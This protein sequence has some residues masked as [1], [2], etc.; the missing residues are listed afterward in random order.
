MDFDYA[1]ALVIAQGIVCFGSTSDDTVRALDAETGEERW[2]F[3]AGGPVRF[4]PQI[5]NGKVFFASDDG[6]VYCLDAAS[7]NLFWKFRTAPN[8]EMLV[9]NHRMISRWPVRTGVLAA[10]GVVYGVAGVWPAEGIFVYALHADT[11]EI[12]WCNDTTGGTPQGALLA[13]GEVLLVPQGNGRPMAFDRRTGE[14]LEWRSPNAWTGTGGSWLTIADEKLFSFGIHRAGT[15]FIRSY[16]LT[17]REVV[18]RGWGSGVVPQPTIEPQ[19][20]PFQSHE[21]GKVSAIVNGGK[22]QARIAYGMALAGET[23]L[24]GHD[25]QV[26]AERTESLNSEFRFGLAGDDLVVFTAVPD[27]KVA[28]APQPW[29]GS[30][31]EVFASV[32][33][34][35]EIGQI[36]LIPATGT[37][38]AHAYRAHDGKFDPAP[39]IRLHGTATD[40]GYE[41]SALVPLKMLLLDKSG[42]YRLEVQVTIPGPDG[43]VARSTLFGSPRAYQ[44]NEKFGQFSLKPQDSSASPAEVKANL[45]DIKPNIIKMAGTGELWN[46]Q[47]QG[48]ARELAVAGG[49]L[50]VSTSDGVIYCFAPADGS[51]GSPKIHDTAAA[52]R[53]ATPPV[54]T[55]QEDVVLR[56]L[57]EA[58]AER[59]Y[60]LVVGDSDGRLSEILATHTELA[61]VH[62]EA[63]A[64]KA[65][66]LRDRLLSRTPL[67]GSKLHLPPVERLDPLPFPQYFANTV[68][69]AG[70]CPGLSGSELYRLLHPNGGILLFPGLKPAQAESLVQQTGAPEPEIRRLADDWVVVRGKLPGALDWDSEVRTDHRVKW[71]L[72]PLWFG[73]PSTRQVQNYR[74]G[75]PGPV[76]ANG[77]YFMQSERALTAVDAFNGAV[78]WSRPIPRPWPGGLCEVDGV[79]YNVSERSEHEK[80]DFARNLRVNDESVFLTLGKAYFRGYG[81]GMMQLEAHT[82]EQVKVFG[83][84]N[85]PT[86]FSLKTPLTW[87]VKNPPESSGKPPAQPAVKIDLQDEGDSLESEAQDEVNSLIKDVIHQSR[88]VP[89]SEEKA[90]ANLKDQDACLTLSHDLSGIRITLVT[91]DSSISKLDAWELFFDFRPVEARYGLYERGAFHIRVSPARDKHTPASWNLVTG[92]QCP[93]LDVSGERD[94]ADTRTTVLL[95]WTEI[96]MLVGVRPTSFDFAA[97]LDA[98]ADGSDEP[99]ERRHLFAD[100]TTDGIN[101]GW[102]R[103]AMDNSQKAIGSESPSIIVASVKDMKDR[104]GWGPVGGRT[105]TDESVKEA[106]GIHPLTGEPVPKVFGIAPVCGGAYSSANVISQ[107]GGLYDL[108]DNS[109]RRLLRGTKNACTTPQIAS[110]GILLISE[111]TGHCVCNY[112]FRTSLAIAP[113]ERRLNED[114]AQ[115]YD[116]DV[117]TQVRQAFINLGAPGDRRDEKGNLWL[118]FPR[119]SEQRTPAQ[120]LNPDHPLPY[121]LGMGDARNGLWYRRPVRSALWLP[122]EIETF[123]LTPVPVVPSQADTEKHTDPA[124]DAVHDESR[125]DELRSYRFSSDRVQIPE[126]NRPWIYSSGAQGI[127]KATLKLNFFRP[128][129]STQVE[130]PIAVDGQLDEAAWGDELQSTNTAPPALP[131]TSTRVSFRHGSQALYVGL[132]RPPMTRWTRAPRKGALADFLSESSP[133]KTGNSKPDKLSP[134]DNWWRLILSSDGGKRAAYFTVTPDGTRSEA[135]LNGTNPNLD[136]AWNSEWKS[137]VHADENAWTLEMA[138]PWSALAEAGVQKESLAVNFLMVDPSL[139]TEALTYLG[140]GGL[141]RCTNFTP[142]GLGTPPQVPQ[143]RFTVRLHFSEPE[144]S[145]KPGQRVFDVLMQRQTVLKDFDVVKESGGP[146][147]AMVREFK[148]IPAS[149]SLALEFL[150][151]VKANRETAVPILSG[152]EVVEEKD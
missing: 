9:G 121:P 5:E 80:A 128:L 109:G 135:L 66:S 18:G 19:L 28:P 48:E 150:P 122:L 51:D 88:G 63:D 12:L 90:R 110:L 46:A 24:L 13:D 79:L 25:G 151:K 91:R 123:N 100:W 11:G 8:E 136:P 85:P 32:P 133:W 33:G 126:T 27:L 95:P 106:P 67:Y 146:R 129:V 144:E 134:K 31:V 69:V 6:M 72:R 30:C 142:L 108:T 70:S 81:G 82:G 96:E 61:V 60:A 89:M 152:L 42:N 118:G 14:F 1:P 113:A 45:A 132:Q 103:I 93:K 102:A 29:K 20:K 94:A 3:I 99:I 139:G 116:R 137:A 124:E 58:R 44:N 98:H 49:R 107:S 2:H 35:P 38:P 57:R 21:R 75:A 119:N 101:N 68:I 50:F 10:D 64:I 7:G 149:E 40:F 54:P 76:V 17:T 105:K 148:G 143:R 52:I 140:I 43:T 36:F 73:G 97:T 145:V 138:I 111:E 127:K 112:P 53:Q 87:L 92:P 23:L 22:P 26:V 62:V 130:A 71:P 37:T 141:D 59:G 65:A 115:F 131:Y 117:D 56:Q 74:Q 147:R 104:A 84:F 86:P 41:L 16:S 114:W 39:E 120:Y 47:V 55:D 77:R 125:A 15:L 4:A 34:K 83:T 78:L